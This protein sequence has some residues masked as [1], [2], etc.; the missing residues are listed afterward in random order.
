MNY[1]LTAPPEDL[2]YLYKASVIKVVDGDTI[3]VLI[4]MGFNISVE[5]RL[6]LLGVD[7]FELRDPDPAKRRLARM[8][9]DFVVNAVACGGLKREVYVR[10][11]KDKTGKYGRM[12]AAVFYQRNLG[13]ERSGGPDDWA[14]LNVELVRR[15]LVEWAAGPLEEEL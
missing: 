1:T 9:K 15:N 4:D 5:K 6:R 8:G 14:C 11:M 2:R 10:T 12:L 13:P 3:D 7:T